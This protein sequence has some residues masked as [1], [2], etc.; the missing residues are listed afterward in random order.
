MSSVEAK[1]RQSPPEEHRPQLKLAEPP[2]RQ[3]AALPDI[4]E[5][6]KSKR[7]FSVRKLGLG[8]A[9][10]A[11]LAGASWYGYDWYTVGRFMVSTDDAYVQADT[12][13]LSAKVAGYVAELPVPENTF[14]N[15]GTTILKLDDGD[16][17]LAIA[18][19][20]DRIALENLVLEAAVLVALGLVALFEGA[21]E[22]GGDLI[23]ESLALSS[24]LG[25]KRTSVEC[26]H[27]LAGVS[28][29]AGE[30]QRAAT[31]SGAAEKLLELIHAPPS[32]TERAVRDR[33]TAS[34]RRELGGEALAKAHTVGREMSLDLAVEY[35]LGDGDA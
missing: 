17:R 22:D 25:D 32:P 3:D 21:F 29:A 23:R 27:A 2:A 31:L 4:V 6:R 1:L 12:S 11:L 13:T 20:Q 24:R 14:V 35:A 30:A 19:A 5:Q 18:S 34:A 15:A 33:F 16:F 26:L 10:V 8:V 7:R 28:A 9:V